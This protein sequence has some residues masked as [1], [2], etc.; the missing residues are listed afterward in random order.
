MPMLKTLTIDELIRKL[1]KEREDC[2]GDTPVFICNPYEDGMGYETLPIS[3]VHWVGGVC[4][5]QVPVNKEV[6]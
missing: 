2:E 1:Q 4:H 5:V 3:D 6:K